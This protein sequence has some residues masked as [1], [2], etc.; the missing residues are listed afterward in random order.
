MRLLSA[1][2]SSFNRSNMSML[3]PEPGLL[4]WMTLSFGVVAFILIKF[5][6]PVILGMVNKRNDFIDSSLEAAKQAHLELDKVKENSE[7]LLA[8]TRQEQSRIIETAN[9]MRAS[10]I[11]AA[12]KQ[13]QVEADKIIAEANRQTEVERE[14]ALQAVQNQVASLSV[15][16]A[17]R[18]L[19]EQ[20]ATEE[21]QSKMVNRLLDEVMHAKS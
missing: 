17:E 15:D 12:K 6:F 16:V 13:A 10:M 18:I 8:Q 2:S 9:Q 7:A 20:L 14:R 11:E 4:F 19:R 1:V 5:G 21:E 3:T